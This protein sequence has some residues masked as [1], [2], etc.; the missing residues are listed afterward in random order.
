VRKFYVGWD[1]GAW[2]CSQKSNSQ[3]AFVVLT[4]DD[5]NL[6]I[7]GKAFRGPL[8]DEI[9]A[10]E[11]VGAL[12]SQLCEV[13]FQPD[14]E[15]VIGID[16]PLGLPEAVQWHFTQAGLPN[17]IE[18][19]AAYNPYL[20][21]RTEQH[22]A[23]KNFPPL[24][25]IKDMIGSQFTKGMHF[26]RKLELLSEPDQVGVWKRG[27]ITA[28]EVYP[29]TCKATDTKGYVSFGSAS[30]QQLF[31]LLR[32]EDLSTVD[33]Q[34]AVYC[35]L[36]AYLFDTR[37]EKLV[38]PL[39]NIAASEGWIWYPEDSIGRKSKKKNSPE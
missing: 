28:I 31:S 33:E 15:F 12:L 22:L 29:A 19:R 27:N 5:D 14:D 38:S 10:I 18:K 3:D 8:R 26:L 7:A 30:V 20:Y 13:Q 34:D 39:A 21:R 17:V 35:A 23:D 32:G 16:T 6:R 2:N 24:S 9:V 37:R 1:V 11:T 36:V 4:A 25:A